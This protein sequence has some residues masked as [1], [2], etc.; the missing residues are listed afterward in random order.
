MTTHSRGTAP[1]TRRPAQDGQTHQGTLADA[2]ATPPR[3]TTQAFPVSPPRCQGLPEV[4]PHLRCEADG[5][6]CSC[7]ERMQLGGDWL[8]WIER[9]LRCG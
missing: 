8:G 4:A 5:W 9:H 6:V 1:R 3:A 2:M 7:G